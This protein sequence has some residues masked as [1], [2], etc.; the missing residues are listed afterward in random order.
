VT[1]RLRGDDTTNGMSKK[2]K[3][4]IGK[5]NTTE[6]RIISHKTKL[7]KMR[8]WKRKQQQP[9]TFWLDVIFFWFVLH[10][11]L[12]VVLLLPRRRFPIARW[13]TYWRCRDCSTTTN[14]QTK[15]RK[16]HHGIP[17]VL[18]FFPFRAN[19]VCATRVC[20]HYVRTNER[21]KKNT[22][23]IHLITPEKELI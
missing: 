13:L 17:I 18:F 7:A 11:S 8:K 6:F 9:L 21:T 1:L 2:I 3:F 22:K 20:L 5:W 12:V 15:K 10:F 19:W 14:K 16:H 4:A 23:H